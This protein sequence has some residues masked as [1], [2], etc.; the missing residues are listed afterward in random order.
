MF[1]LHFISDLLVST[2]DL[3]L[4]ALLGCTWFSNPSVVVGWRFHNRLSMWMRRGHLNSHEGWLCPVTGSSTLVI[5]NSVRLNPV[6]SRLLTYWQKWPYLASK[7]F[8]LQLWAT[9]G[10]L[11][12]PKVSKKN[13]TLTLGKGRPNMMLI[14]LVKMGEQE[15]SKG[16]FPCDPPTN[17]FLENSGW[18]KYPFQ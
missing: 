5:V 4:W 8:V 18:V 3:G 17:C 16:Q 14:I 9:L 1:D 7:I 2:R 6:V 12:W 11:A 15:R 10:L 13:S